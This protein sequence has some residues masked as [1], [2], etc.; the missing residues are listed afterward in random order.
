MNNFP[1]EP[2]QERCDFLIGSYVH[3]ISP[4]KGTDVKSSM[5]VAMRA[6][7]LSR[8]AIVQPKLASCDFLFAPP[9]IEAIGMLD[10]K[11]IDK[12]FNLG[13]ENACKEMPKL[14]QLLKKE[15]EAAFDY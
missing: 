12:S 8:F 10:R 7:D 11:A 1:L 9:G 15:W 2:L 5:Q 6:M 3:P 13:Y 14:Q 4:I